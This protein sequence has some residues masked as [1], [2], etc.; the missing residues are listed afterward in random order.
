[1]NLL[2]AS[3]QASLLLEICAFVVQVQIRVLI[4]NS[5]TF[6][7]KNK[8]VYRE[9]FEAFEC[10]LMREMFERKLEAGR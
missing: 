1:M 4:W 6:V 7:L 3:L 9:A 5:K 8:E 2:E 10:N